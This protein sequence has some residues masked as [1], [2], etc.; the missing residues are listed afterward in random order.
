VYLPFDPI[1]TVVAPNMI[2]ARLT[3]RM[4]SQLGTS[5]ALNYIREGKLLVADAATPE[6][7]LGWAGVDQAIRLLN[8]QPLAAENL[9]IKLLDK[10]T[11]PAK[12]EAFTGA[13]DGADY[14]SKYLA[15]W[16]IG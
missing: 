16:G 13:G 10:V 5:D 1:V 7:W 8:K 9:P 14:Q 12:G 11:L 15:L 6:A 4:Y 2:N 3:Q